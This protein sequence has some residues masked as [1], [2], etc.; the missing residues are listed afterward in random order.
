M[1]SYDNE[2]LLWKKISI[3]EIRPLIKNTSLGT[4]FYD[5]KK[6]LKRLGISGTVSQATQQVDVFDEVSYPFITQIK[7]EEGI[8]FVIVFEK[9]RSKLIIGD[10]NKEKQQTIPIK[11][12]MDVWIPF[13]LEIDL[14]KSE[15]QYEIE[16][17]TK[18]VSLWK[19][20]KLVRVHLAISFFLSIAVYVLGV[21]LANIYS[22]YFN[23]L[24]PQKMSALALQLMGVYLLINVLNFALS[25]SNNFL[26]NLM[27]KKID[28]QIIEK[29]F[30]GLLEKPNMAI[31]SYEVGELLTNLS[32]VLMIRQRF[33]TYL[34][35][36]PVSGLTM[37][38]SF[39]L[40]W[41]SE[42]RLAGLVIVL[43]IALT[44]VLY[45]SQGRYEKLSKSLV[46]TGQEFN[47]T[48]INI[49]S[50]MSVIKQLSLET[51]FGD[52]GVDK[53]RNYIATRTKVF[54]F[55]SA[56]LD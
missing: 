32:N 17:K 9:K 30:K 10:S 40:L 35:M 16:Q 27:S 4:N 52:R 12:F 26:Y 53:L 2:E 48:V 43:V 28:R 21:V 41:N 3:C 22:L 51:E 13:V 24:I 5:L 36:I 45:L 11:K 15:I 47:S 54:N 44:V 14:G 29:Y 19:I 7:N 50:N 20:M 38:Y 46:N 37:V 42:S 18:D 31:E 23:F 39:Y 34:Q 56:T 8:H 25:F 49:F 33:L 6:G 55:E 1:R